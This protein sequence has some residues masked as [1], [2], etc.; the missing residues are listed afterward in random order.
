M[1]RAGPAPFF[2]ERPSLSILLGKAADTVSE[3]GSQFTNYSHNLNELAYRYPKG[4][5]H[6]AVLGQFKRGKSILLNALTGEPILPV[7]V[8]PSTAA[9]TF[10]QY[11]EE[12]KICVQYPGGRP[13]GEFTALDLLFNPLRIK[14]TL[15]V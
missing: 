7:G 8:V 2:D 4:R 15:R 1:T 12:A 11:G 5:F 14:A 3:F 10:P 9:P 6:L 13:T